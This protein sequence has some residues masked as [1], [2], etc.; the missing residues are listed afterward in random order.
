MRWL[1]QNWA[2]LAVGVSV[3]S[4]VTVFA[5][6]W[7]EPSKLAAVGSLFG[8]LITALLVLITIEYV[9]T[10]QHTVRLMKAQW[11]A[12]NTLEVFVGLRSRDDHARIWIANLGRPDIMLTKA[13]IQLP[14][15]SPLML[16][17]HM[18]VRSAAKRS[19]ALPEKMWQGLESSQ[20]VRSDG[21]L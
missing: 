16:Y 18:I 6:C 1:K 10:N 21:A 19:F 3:A 2:Y 20:N 11:K 13:V 5:V 9:R 8:F 7:N 17:K 4:G 15:R 14:D 12:Q